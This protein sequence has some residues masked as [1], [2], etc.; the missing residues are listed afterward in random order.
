MRHSPHLAHHRSCSV[1]TARH[2]LVAISLL[3]SVVAKGAGNAETSMSPEKLAE[4]LEQQMVYGPQLKANIS[5]SVV[6]AE[7][8]NPIEQV[9]N[10][11]PMRWISTGQ[12]AKGDY[13]YQRGM[14]SSQEALWFLSG[15][16]NSQDVFS[17]TFQEYPV[18][19]GYYRDTMHLYA[20]PLVVRGRVAKRPAG[21]MTMGAGPQRAIVTVLPK[22]ELSL[23]GA[24]GVMIGTPDLTRPELYRYYEWARAY[25]ELENALTNAGMRL[26]PGSR[27]KQFSDA[28]RSVMTPS[29]PA[30]E[31]FRAGRMSLSSDQL[32]DPANDPDPLLRL[33]RQYL[34]D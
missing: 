33:L 3:L 19:G 5:P 6:C 12:S 17:V 27:G 16:P 21:L 31:R 9:F 34:S 1:L 29:N 20:K 7:L 2:G 4:C 11:G 23:L 25:L 24:E 26:H 28:L 8:A 13:I 32:K 15:K 10:A 22:A 14:G 30:F 18:S